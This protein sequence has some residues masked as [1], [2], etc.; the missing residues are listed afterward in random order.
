[1]IDPYAS[2]PAIEI[3]GML[4]QVRD[5]TSAM[6]AYEE[7]MYGPEKHDAEGTAQWSNLL[8]QYCVL[9][10]LSMFLYWSIGAVKLLAA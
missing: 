2:L 8:R 7:M 10:T 5:G 6:Q 1:M 9:D 3:P 4:R